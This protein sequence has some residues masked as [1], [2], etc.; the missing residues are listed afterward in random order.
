MKNSR[1]ARRYAQALLEAAERDRALDA[2]LADLRLLQE[3]ISESRDFRLFLKSPVIKGQ[4]KLSILRN[5]FGGSL[6]ALTMD[7]LRLLVEKNREALLSE[8]IVELF[9]MNDTRLG[10]VSLELK[11]AAEL[12]DDHR[13]AITR[14]FENLTG[15]KIKISFSIDTSLKG[16]IL[17]RVGDTVYDGSVKR[18]LELLR[19]RFAEGVVSN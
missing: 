18:Q 12:S 9:L 8:V 15:K 16:G 10:I 7:F 19:Q 5:V 6:G 2:V 4:T 1:V 14:R 11:A 3:H 17:V 13:T